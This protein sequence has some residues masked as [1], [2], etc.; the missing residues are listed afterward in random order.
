MTTRLYYQ[1]V[2]ELVE[3][4]GGTMQYVRKRL[5]SG[6]AW[7][8]CHFHG[9]SDVF[10]RAGGLQDGKRLYFNDLDSLY[11]RGPSTFA[12]IEKQALVFDAEEKLVGMLETPG[13]VAVLDEE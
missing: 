2:R 7:V 6:G 8:I 13:S 1:E 4:R 11:V 3:R 5:P 9:K 12:T 10:P